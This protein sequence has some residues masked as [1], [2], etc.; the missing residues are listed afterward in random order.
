MVICGEC[1]ERNPDGVQFCG[2]CGAYLE[3]RGARAD[4]QPVSTAASTP[5]SGAPTP[6]PG[7]QPGH[8]PG[9]QTGPQPGPQPGFQPGIQPGPPSEAL[10]GQPAPLKPTEPVPR[11][12]RYADS[13]Q[14]SPP[15]PGD[16]ICGQCGT[17]NVPTRRFCNRCGAALAEATVVPTPWWRRLLPRRTRKVP[18]S[19]DRPRRRA[20]RGPLSRAF[21]VLRW[22]LVLLL[23]LAGLAYVLA[24]GVRSWA[25]PSIATVTRKAQSIFK[26]VYVPVRPVEVS[27]SGELPDHPA[28]AASDGF[29]TTHWALPEGGSESILVFRFERPVNL[30]RAIVHSGA[31][32]DF[33]ATHRPERLHLVFST[34]Q[35]T[36]LTLVDTPDQQIHGLPGSEGATSVEIHIVSLYHAIS[37]PNLALT[38]IEFFEQVS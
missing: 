32:D 26:P 16:L 21:R 14:P 31:S 7:P 10:S 3:W 5:N 29:T 12:R 9:F 1:G 30:K 13:P 33:Q 34:G 24:P 6:Q 23:V 18:K 27:A 8:H 36:D 4:G 38:E 20:S 15:S 11:R 28:R 2:A 37:G 19:G 35:T 22:G 17:G 25:N